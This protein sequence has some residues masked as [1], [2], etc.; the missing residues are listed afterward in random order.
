MLT[1]SFVLTMLTL[2]AAESHSTRI[3]PEQCFDM[4]QF[5]PESLV[6]AWNIKTHQVEWRN[7]KKA[8]AK[9]ALPETWP[10]H[11]QARWL[12]TRDHQGDTWDTVA[13]QPMKA[14]KDHADSM[15]KQYEA[16]YHKRQSCQRCFS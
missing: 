13:T 15:M 7:L 8:K 2:E 9:Y 14:I 4:E 16:D 5:P 10:E 12:W 6:D 11:M 1:P 3:H